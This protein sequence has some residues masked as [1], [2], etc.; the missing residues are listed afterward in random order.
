MEYVADTSF[1]IHHPKIF[2][3]KVIIPP[4]VLEEIKSPIVRL[5]LELWGFEVLEPKEKYIEKVKKEA[6]KIGYLD[7]LSDVDIE[8][9]ALAL[10]RRAVL[11]TDDFSMQNVAKRLKIKFKGNK[12]IKKYKKRRKKKEERLKE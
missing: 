2:E 8:V 12:T 4:S 3:R 9:L 1:I 7:K 6:E 11:L 10:E 5:K